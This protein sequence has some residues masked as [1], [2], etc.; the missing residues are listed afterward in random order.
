MLKTSL[1]VMAIGFVMLISGI[2]SKGENQLW[3]LLLA[4]LFIGGGYYLNMR[5]EKDR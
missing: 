3:T 1:F 4:A 5:A 2:V